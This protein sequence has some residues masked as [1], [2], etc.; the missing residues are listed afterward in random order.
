MN[1]NKNDSFC[2]PER[3]GN[4][5][6]KGSSEHQMCRRG[7][8]KLEEF[9]LNSHAFFSVVEGIYWVANKCQAQTYPNIDS[10]LDVYS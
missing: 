1:N 5:V 7:D 2:I 9:V 10:L 6:K 8:W 3:E 4:E